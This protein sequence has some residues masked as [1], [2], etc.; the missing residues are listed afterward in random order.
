MSCISFMIILLVNKYLGNTLTYE[1]YDVRFRSGGLISGDD[2]F[3]LLVSTRGH[4]LREGEGP[5]N[6]FSRA[7]AFKQIWKLRIFGVV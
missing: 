3:V 2:S 4:L 5:N 7:L 6:F 1:R